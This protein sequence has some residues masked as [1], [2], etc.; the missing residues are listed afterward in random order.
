MADE[1]DPTD[2]PTFDAAAEDETYDP[3]EY[4]TYGQEDAGDEDDD[5]D[6]SSV[7]FS[8][9]GSEQQDVK[10]PSD[11]AHQTAPA[12][13][14]QAPKPKQKVAGFIVEESDDEQ[15]ESAPPPSQLNGMA[16]A[17]SGLG[18]VAVSEAQD[19]SLSSA[20]QDT[21]ASSTSLNGS[22]T[23]HVPASTSPSLPDP[24]LQQPA[25]EQGKTFS[26]VASAQASLAP[27][28]QPSAPAAAATPQQSAMQTNGA[29]LQPPP[30]LPHDKVGLLE[31]RIKDDPKGDTDAW[32]S[33]IEHY[34]D[35]GQYDYVRHVYDRFFKVFPT[36]VCL[37]LSLLL[38]LGLEKCRSWLLTRTANHPLLSE[39][40]R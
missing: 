27:T 37:S 29:T 12:A 21:A 7:N 28:P 4:E 33:L 35:K 31:D 30:R 18:A 39:S 22:A 24:S 20:P 15:D 32:M 17:Q 13:T 19:V 9:D 5:Y 3:T 40:S 16:S 25:P 2:P 26:P 34:Y 8:G 38:A 11:Q 10:T 14:E 6:P 1:Y 36:A 23:V